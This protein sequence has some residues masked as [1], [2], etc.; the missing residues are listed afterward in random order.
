MYRLFRLGL[1]VAVGWWVFNPL[2]A[3]DQAQPLES[4]KLLFEDSLQRYRNEHRKKVAELGERYVERLDAVK[5]YYQQMGNLEGVLKVKEE[6]DHIRK[7]QE[8]PVIG[9]GAFP[10]L[11]G[12]RSQYQ[13]GM[14]LLTQDLN[15]NVEKL[16][17]VY[18][19]HLKILQTK[20]TRE[21]RIDEALAVRD[22]IS[23]RESGIP[24]NPVAE[25]SGS[26]VAKEDRFDML[27]GMPQR[28]RQVLVLTEGLQR[29]P[30]LI[31]DRE[32]KLK[33]GGLILRGGVVE[34]DGM[35]KELAE[36]VRKTGE[37]TL[38]AEVVP[39]SLN[40][41][42]PARIIS[43]SKGSNER[44]FTLGQQHDRLILRL[45]TSDTNKNGTSPDLDLGPLKKGQN[46]KVVFSYS[47]RGVVCVRDGMQVA[48]GDV[49][50]EL[51][52]WEEMPLVLGNEVGGDRPWQGRIL[53][54]KISNTA[55][56]PEEAKKIF[57]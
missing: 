8:L 43:Y 12:V 54:F 57:N 34:I 19:A 17:R 31:L 2:C 3:Q 48:V 47:K 22:E 39:E 35:E 29:K 21:N 11:A 15:G 20:L 9:E 46:T 49:T 45:R 7:P 28:A 27:W 50:G 14:D 24:E 4:S 44:N 6:Q 56:S 36:A 55:L 5:E 52:N 26:T 23:R 41:H 40:P 51:S 33:K 53:N 30:N 18:L 38:M 25:T 1:F 42:G 32:S 13:R 37:W 10:E 16:T